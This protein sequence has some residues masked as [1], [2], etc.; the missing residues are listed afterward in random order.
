MEEFEGLLY[1]QSTSSQ[2]QSLLI[3][4]YMKGNTTIAYNFPKISLCSASYLSCKTRRNTFPVAVL[5]IYTWPNASDGIEIKSAQLTSPTTSIPPRSHLYL[6]RF[7]CVQV[8]RVSIVFTSPLRLPSSLRTTH[9][10]GTFSSDVRPP[11]TPAT[12]TSIIRWS[13]CALKTDSI[14]VGDTWFPDTFRVS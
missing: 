1:I 7:S 13:G 2:G 5:G 4:K 10:R 14:S 8:M 3:D 6:V 9:A 11:L 12:D